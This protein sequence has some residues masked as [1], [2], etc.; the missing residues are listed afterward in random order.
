MTRSPQVESLNRLL[1]SINANRDE[2][3][4][5]AVWFGVWV[6]VGGWK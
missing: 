6:I 1:A 3:F 4:A 5:V 2:V